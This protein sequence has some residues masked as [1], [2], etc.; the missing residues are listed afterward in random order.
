[1]SFNPD[2]VS[3]INLTFCIA[4]VILSVWWCRKTGSRTPLFVGLAFGLFGISHI[5][6][7]TNLNKTFEQFQ[8]AVRIG[9]QQVDGG[10]DNLT[11]ERQDG[12]DGKGNGQDRLLHGST[13]GIVWRPGGGG[14]PRPVYDTAWQKSSFRRARGLANP[15]ATCYHAGVALRFQGHSIG[16]TAP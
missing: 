12:G 9:I 3:L 2:P 11:L 13:P 10:G 7:L 8:I 14:L 1:M 5:L 4:V 16:D 6:V 15:A